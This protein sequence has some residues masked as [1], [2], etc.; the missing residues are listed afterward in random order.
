MVLFATDNNLEMMAAADAIFMDSTFKISPPQF[1][2]LFTLHIIYI[3]FIIP[4]VYALLK[5]KSSDTYYQIFATLRRKMATFNL[6]L[7]P[8]TL[9]SNRPYYKKCLFRNPN[10]SYETKDKRTPT[11]DQCLTR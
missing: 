4:V 1:M 8:L 11:K 2:Q 6:I 7:N 9:V 3:G 10:S 5:D